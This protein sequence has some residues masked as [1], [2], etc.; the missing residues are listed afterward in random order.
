M[1]AY[2]SFQKPL[3]RLKSRERKVILFVGD[4]LAVLLALALALFL[5]SSSKTEYFRFS[6]DFLKERVPFWFYLLPVGWLLM[7][8]ELYDVARA[9]NRKQIVSGLT[10]IA[11][12]SFTIYLAIY[13]TSAPDSLPRLGVAIFILGS[14]LGTLLWR[15]VYIAVFTSPSFMRRVLIIGAGRSGIRLVEI[16]KGL[17]PPPFYLVGLIDDNPEK[18]G[19]S[20]QG[21][22]I[23]GG[24][25]ALADIIREQDVTDLIFSISGEMNPKMFSTLL[26]A[27]E[28]GIQIT[29]MPTVYEELL[30]RVPIFLLESDWVLRSFVDQMNREG[31][32]ELSSRM[33]DVM[34]G[35][36]GVGLLLLFTPLIS[37]LTLIDSGRPVFYKQERLGKN[38]RP[39]QILK[40]RTMRQ[41]AEKDGVARPASEH[42]ER[43]TRVGRLLRKSHLDELPQFI[44]VL[45]GEMSLVGP[46]AERPQLVCLLQEKIPFYR[47]RLFVRPGLT[48]WAQVN[49]GYASNAEQNAIKL[50][51][52]LYY[53]KHRTVWLD[54]S[55]LLRTVG[56]V[57]GLKGN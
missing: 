35:L 57:V 39:Y 46:R 44:N 55:I 30:G 54:I 31:L 7:M 49:Y 50:E 4:L 34:G 37:L 24:A 12:V 19:K 42:D 38:G 5:W 9:A 13:F 2:S 52:D 18:H 43:V 36:V 25:E 23:L 32:S 26:E 41:D 27:A 21:F 15:L 56:A 51:Y 3:W 1:A 20:V 40:F 22:P 29:T 53:I 45:R 10:M 6:L 47:A 28:A 33:L 11:L 17:W 48:G 8:M 14:Y 16:F